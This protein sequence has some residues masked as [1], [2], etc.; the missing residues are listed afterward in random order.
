MPMLIVMSSGHLRV[1][2]LVLLA[3]D[4]YFWNQWIL[5]RQYLSIFDI[6]S[7]P[8]KAQEEDQE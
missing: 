8:K 3:L 6:Y 2:F 7:L 4:T 1:Y 5:D